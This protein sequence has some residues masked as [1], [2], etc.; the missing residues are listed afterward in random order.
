[1][2]ATPRLRVSEDYGATWHGANADGVL[3]ASDPRNERIFYAT[4]RIGE[5][6]TSIDGGRSFSE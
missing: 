3:V 2:V 1:M 5:L 4:N 6:L